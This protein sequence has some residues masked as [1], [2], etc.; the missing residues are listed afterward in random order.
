[1]VGWR[2]R[3]RWIERSYTVLSA[4]GAF[5]V[6][7]KRRLVGLLLLWMGTMVQTGILVI[8]GFA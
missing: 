4:G 8:D 5:R 1:M 7:Q 6:S 2:M 3:W